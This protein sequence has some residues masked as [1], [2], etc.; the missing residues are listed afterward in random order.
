MEGRR[1]LSK[2]DHWMNLAKQQVLIRVKCFYQYGQVVMGSEIYSSEV[3]D[4]TLPRKASS[5]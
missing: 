2:P 3:A 1:R 4:V 5:E